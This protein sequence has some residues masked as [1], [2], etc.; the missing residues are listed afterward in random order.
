[1]EGNVL[2][3]QLPE[4]VFHDVGMQAIANLIH[5]HGIPINEAQDGHFHVGPMKQEV[6]EEITRKFAS[7]HDSAMYGLTFST[8]ET[9]PVG[10]KKIFGGKQV[11]IIVSPDNE[12]GQKNLGHLIKCVNEKPR[13]RFLT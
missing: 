3:K 9:E 12:V 11:K 7:K 10:F 5:K 8:K 4:P 6:G 13:L 2:A 1:L